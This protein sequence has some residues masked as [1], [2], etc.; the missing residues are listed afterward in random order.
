MY[1]GTMKSLF[2]KIPVELPKPTSPKEKNQ[3]LLYVIG[4]GWYMNKFNDKF[5]LLKK[6]K[7]IRKS[8]E[9]G[10]EIKRKTSNE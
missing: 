1:S 2:Q 6:R 3:P 7:K 8:Q 4:G 5:S 9:K 10:D